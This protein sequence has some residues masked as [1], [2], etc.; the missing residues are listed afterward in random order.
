MS[1]TGNLVKVERIMKNEQDEK[2]LKEKA[3]SSKTWAGLSFDP[4]V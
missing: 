4:L 1:R 3:V 2:F